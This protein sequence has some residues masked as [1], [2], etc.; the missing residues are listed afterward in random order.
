MIPVDG[1]LAED[2]VAQ[3]RPTPV[4]AIKAGK[5]RLFYP[6]TDGGRDCVYEGNWLVIFGDES[7][8]DTVRM[9]QYSDDQ[10]RSQFEVLGSR[11]AEK[12]IRASDSDRKKRAGR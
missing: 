12:V 1:D 9:Q 2:V 11:T 4:R 6:T 10:F 5:G 3:R 8:P 7:A